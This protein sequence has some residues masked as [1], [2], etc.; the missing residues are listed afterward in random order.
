MTNGPTEGAPNCRWQKVENARLGERFEASAGHERRV[1]G[2]SILTNFY[3]PLPA[4]FCLLH[5]AFCLLPAVHSRGTNQ[6]KHA[7][8]GQQWD[9]SRQKERGVVGKLIHQPPHQQCEKNSG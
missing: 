3:C 2:H 8:R 6:Q 4:A 1:K 5:S 7:E 9:R